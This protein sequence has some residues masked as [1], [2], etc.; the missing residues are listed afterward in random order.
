VAEILVLV[1]DKPFR[2]LVAACLPSHALKIVK[3]PE[4]VPEALA[5]GRYA[6][7]II[8]NMGVS[9]FAAVDAVPVDRACPVLFLTGL[10]SGRINRD[11]LSK[12]IPYLTTP[13]ELTSLLRELRIA[14]DDAV[15]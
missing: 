1:N 9:P 5:Q 10:M 12:G 3:S 2:D 6:L 15:L 7:A 14:L 13:I 4:E 8:T 11:C